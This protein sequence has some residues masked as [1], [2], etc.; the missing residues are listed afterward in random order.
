MEQVVKIHLFYPIIIIFLLLLGG[1][2]YHIIL[3]LFAKDSTT[4]M[5]FMFEKST[6]NQK[7]L[8]LDATDKIIRLADNV[9]K[10]DYTKAEAKEMHEINK[11]IKNIEE[12]LEKLEHNNRQK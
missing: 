9:V 5:Q 10:L 1:L 12:R 6:D 4:K 2:I 8:Q 3:A 11:K 7:E